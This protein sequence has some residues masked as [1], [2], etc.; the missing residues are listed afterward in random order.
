MLNP[1]VLTPI[2]TSDDREARV[3]ALMQ[4]LRG[5]AEATLRS[6]AESLVDLPEDQAFGAIEFTLRDQVQRLAATAH[7]TGLQVGKK[8]GT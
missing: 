6:L 3:Q 8:R 7:Q 1:Q 2:P 4:Q 5:A